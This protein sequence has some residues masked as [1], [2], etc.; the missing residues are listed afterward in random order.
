MI[1]VRMVNFWCRII[2]GN[3]NKFSFILYSLTK[4]LH[5]DPSNNFNSNWITKLK[6]ILYHSGLGFLWISHDTCNGNLI[7]DTVKTRL[8]DIANQKWCADV[9]TKNSCV[10]FR[11]FKN[12]LVLEKYL[13][14]LD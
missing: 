3:Q 8:Y 5:E 6:D 12:N 10:N 11:I 2:S 1:K 7:K 14:N 13:I 9:D 4:K